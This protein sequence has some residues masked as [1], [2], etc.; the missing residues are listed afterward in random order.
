[1]YRKKLSTEIS[2]KEDLLKEKM[3]NCI[4][5][6]SSS[7][8]V[9]IKNSEHERIKSDLSFILNYLSDSI[10]FKNNELF[11]DF[12][13]WLKE[14]LE[15]LDSK[16]RNFFRYFDC[17]KEVIKRNFSSKKY[18]YIVK[19]IN[20]SEQKINSKANENKSFINEKNKKGK[21][22]KKYLDYILNYKKQEAVNF[23]LNEVKNELSIEE[24]YL[25]IFQVAQREIGRLWHNNE[26]SIAQE[27]YASLITQ[28]I[29]SQLYPEILSSSNNKAKVLTTAIGNELHEIGI[30]MI[31]DL[32]DIDG[33][34]TIHLGANTPTSTIIETIINEDVHF[35][36]ISVTIASHL[37]ELEKLLFEIRSNE[38]ISNIKIMVVGYAFNKDKERWKDFA[39]DAYSPNAKDAVK[40]MNE[41]YRRSNNE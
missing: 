10:H 18:E 20:K 16:K 17:L 4:L 41:L 31:A 33:F 37:K 7:K 36:G 11:Y 38:K 25:D 2:K 24:I 1:M 30:R 27:H 12:S 35:M 9:Y 22:A 5:K 28:L 3:M 8:E 13:F 23:I 15:N 29:I 21:M 34:D 19:I 14:H 32:L 6:N 40:K 39:V 26:I